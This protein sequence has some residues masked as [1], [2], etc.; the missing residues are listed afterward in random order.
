VKLTEIVAASKQLSGTQ[1]WLLREPNQLCLVSAL[2][3]DGVTMEAVQL[4]MRALQD[5]PDRAVMIQL[6]YNPPRGR[7]E[8]L[9]R[10]EWRPLTSHTNDNR[11]PEP[12]RLMIIRTSHMHRFEHNYNEAGDRMVRGNLPRAIPLEPDPANFGELLEVASKELKISDLSRV[13]VPPWQA[14]MV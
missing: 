5:E 4:R 7:N 10:V 3:A 13:T 1:S 11:A 6:E 9:I 14:R 12:Y 8:R 2:E